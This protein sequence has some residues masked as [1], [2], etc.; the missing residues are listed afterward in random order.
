MSLAQLRRTVTELRERVTPKGGRVRVEIWGN[1]ETDLI[2]GVVV[3]NRRPDEFL[4]INV[5]FGLEAEG[6][7]LPQRVHTRAEV[8]ANWE[9][10]ERKGYVIQASFFGDANLKGWYETGIGFTPNGDVYTWLA[11]V[12][13]G[14]SS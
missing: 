3:H 8:L 1:G 10:W 12:F 4:A 9:E 5:P 6:E 11:D 2:D 14:V 7:R 13:N